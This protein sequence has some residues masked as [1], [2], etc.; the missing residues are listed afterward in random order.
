MGKAPVETT[1]TIETNFDP[2]KN[3]IHFDEVSCTVSKDGKIWTCQCCLPGECDIVK[4]NHDGGSGGLTTTTDIMRTTTVGKFQIVSLN[5][6]ASSPKQ[7]T[8]SN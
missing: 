3:I 1:N 2:P 4:N 5:N 8:R 7:W 6:F